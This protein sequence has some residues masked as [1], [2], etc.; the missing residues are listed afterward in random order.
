M[1]PE[2]IAGFAMGAFGTLMIC[3]V[4]MPG[5][6]QQTGPSITF[7]NDEPG[8]PYFICGRCRENDITKAREKT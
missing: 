1:I 5:K 7:T 6:R 8:C 2:Y 3:L 4:L